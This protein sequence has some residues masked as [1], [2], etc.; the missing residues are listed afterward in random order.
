MRRRARRRPAAPCLR[1]TRAS[2]AAG[3]DVG[4]PVG[5]PRLGHR[6]G[7]VA[8]ADDGDGALPRGL[9]HRARDGEGAVVERRRLE[10]AHRA[11][12]D[13]GAGGGDAPGEVAL[14]GRIDI[15]HRPARGDGVARHRPGLRAALELPRDHRARRQHQLV[16]RLGHQLPGQVEP[17]VLDERLAG[18]E[19]HGLE[20]G[21]GHGAA[22]QHGVHLRQE[23]LDEIDLAADLGAAE[24][25]DERPLR[26]VQRLAQ[27]AQLLLHQKA[28]HR[29]LE[30]AGHRLRARVG[31]VGGAEGVVD[32]EI[33]ERG[34]ALGERR[35]VGL[36][37]RDRTG[38]S[39][40]PRRRRAA[41]GGWPSPPPRTSDRPGR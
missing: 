26:P 6:R 19:P 39:P 17:I 1:G 30:Q 9:G 13:H 4:D 14:G 23:R 5:E 31:P 35:V 8:A 10:H 28:R 41:V 2:P 3:R 21:A 33:A 34:E 32:V 38:C 36:F 27:V 25:R 24:D 7:G 15:E 16:P 22:E 20:E 29:R 12:P 40:P 37:S 11:V 18:L